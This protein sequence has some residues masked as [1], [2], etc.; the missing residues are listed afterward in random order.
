MYFMLHV[1][2]Q[3]NP[4]NSIP[5]SPQWLYAKPGDSKVGF[6]ITLV[7]SAFLYMAVTDFLFLGS[8]L[9]LLHSMPIQSFFKPYVS[10]FLVV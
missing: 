9:F 2:D 5:L 3:V 8:Y 6:L 1:V 7:V 10:Y 4:E